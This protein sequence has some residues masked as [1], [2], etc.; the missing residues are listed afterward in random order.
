MTLKR[1]ILEMGT[2]NDLHGSDYTKAALRAVGLAVLIELAAGLL[3][4]KPMWQRQYLSRRRRQSL[5]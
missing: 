1:V 2:G 3:H 4:P 5:G